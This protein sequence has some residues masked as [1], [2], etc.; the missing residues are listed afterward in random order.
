MSITNECYGQ[1]LVLIKH[2]WNSSL[3]W[4]LTLVYLCSVLAGGGTA[5]VVRL[6]DLIAWLKGSANVLPGI[7]VPSPATSSK[8]PF[9]MFFVKEAKQIF[10]LSVFNFLIW[11]LYE[12]IYF[13]L[14]SC[15][16]SCLYCIYYFLAKY[17]SIQANYH[18][19]VK[20]KLCTFLR[21]PFLTF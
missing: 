11:P 10:S 1:I 20:F 15:F 4:F 18:C 21:K 7:E 19:S 3:I 6:K 14:Q 2:F 13:Y 8:R 9:G 5:F 16:S 17:K 12:Y